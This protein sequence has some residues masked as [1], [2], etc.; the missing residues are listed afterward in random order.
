[1]RTPLPLP[2]GLALA[3]GLWTCTPWISSGEL[4]AQQETQ[5]GSQPTAQPTDKEAVRLAEE[6][7][8]DKAALQKF[9]RSY[10]QGAIRLTRNGNPD[11]EAIAEV[12]KVLANIA[13]WN[14]LEAAR[15]LFDVA[16]IQLDPPGG[17]NTSMG[18][19]D[20]Y[21]ELKVWKVRGL[22]RQHITKMDGDGIEDF[23]LTHA[24]QRVSASKL[25]D[26]ATTA[27]AA[28]RILGDR[29]SDKATRIILHA[30]RH[31][32]PTVRVQA[33][34][35]LSKG[36]TLQTVSN[37]IELL[38]DA[39]PN[40]RIAALNGIARALGPHTDETRNTKF[41]KEVIKLRDQVVTKVGALMGRERVW[42]VRAAARECLVA[43]RST[44]IIPVLIKALK[45]ELRRKKDPWALDVRLHRTLE[46]LTGQ[47][48]T[49]GQSDL[50]E[51]FWRKE[52][53][54]F[55]FAPADKKAAIAAQKETGRYHKFF[56][57]DIESD[58]LLFILDFSGSMAQPAT[59]KSMGTS[60]FPRGSTTTKAKL[61]VAEM[62]SM[63]MALPDNTMFN[64][65]VFSEDVRVW[66]SQGSR[67]ALVRLD[68]DARDDLLA[69]F[70]DSL[71]PRGKTNLHGA[72]DKAFRFGGRGVFDRYYE[73]GFDTIYILSD[74]APTYGKVTDTDEILRLVAETNRLR[75]ITI[76][77]I[78]FGDKNE[79]LFMGKLA[80]ENGGRHIH[81]E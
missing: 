66:R 27:G 33:V 55:A 6:F 56:K 3:L 47:K 48:M 62:R 16:T 41:D 76:N 53:G 71:L 9:L 57:I 38:R 40:V 17:A 58:R 5:P 81:V 20:F 43:L 19:L 68:D 26:V 50:W 78:T 52:G 23:L 37:F 2:Q 25:R 14:N 45:A 4:C 7:A 44:V 75:R 49:L 21:A 65:V 77:A 11:L 74:G 69:S 30:T 34:N 54:S 39:E 70:L 46:G 10:A 36:A 67:P 64:I 18:K 13:K 35:A 24:R 12:D 72:L 22:A 51:A 60:A 8:N 42:Q 80:K 1:M 59:L 79:M 61:V 29:K 63:I 28:L 32:E 31:L 15:L 73:A